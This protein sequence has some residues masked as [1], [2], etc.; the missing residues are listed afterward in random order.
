MT[1]DKQALAI[2]NKYDVHNTNTI[3]SGYVVSLIQWQLDQGLRRHLSQSLIGFRFLA[4]VEGLAAKN[5][6][7]LDG[8]NDGIALEDMGHI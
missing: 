3:L 7:M 2:Y 5:E 6:V 1:R 8:F 4:I